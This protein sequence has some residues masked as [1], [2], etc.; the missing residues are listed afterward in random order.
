LHEGAGWRPCVACGGA[1][2]RGGGAWASKAIS[3][4]AGSARW[5]V[6]ARAARERRHLGWRRVVVENHV[7]QSEQPYAPSRELL[8]PRYAL[9]QARDGWGGVGRGEPALRSLEGGGVGE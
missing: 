1:R 6:T 2:A 5:W 7:E 8:P 4:A 9:K 3:P